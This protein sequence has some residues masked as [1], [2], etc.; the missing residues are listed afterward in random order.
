MTIAIAAAHVQIIIGREHDSVR[1]STAESGPQQYGI[2][3]QKTFFALLHCAGRAG[4]AELGP[5]R[6]GALDHGI[7]GVR[8]TH[9]FVEERGRHVERGKRVRFV[10]DERVVLSVVGFVANR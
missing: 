8:E 2:D 3:A 1:M 7:L 10:A 4:R 5:T 6:R 9:E